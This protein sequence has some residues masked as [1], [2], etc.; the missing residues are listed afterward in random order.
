M[1]HLVTL[2]GLIIVGVCVLLGLTYYDTPDRKEVRTQKLTVIDKRG[3]P[4]LEITVGDSGPYIRLWDTHKKHFVDVY[5][6]DL[7]KA[8]GVKIRDDKSDIRLERNWR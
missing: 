1:K 4:R 7:E 5:V 2:Y 3:E 6:D 8:Y